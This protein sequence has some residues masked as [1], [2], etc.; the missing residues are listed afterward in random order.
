MYSTSMM[1]EGAGRRAWTDMWH[2]LWIRYLDRQNPTTVEL[3]QPI[4]PHYKPSI[5]DVSCSDFFY[6]EAGITIHTWS[7]FMKVCIG[8]RIE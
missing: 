7:S 5:E 4:L 8:Q 2:E 1:Y 3:D 6:R